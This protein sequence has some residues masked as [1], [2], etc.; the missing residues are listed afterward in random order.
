MVSPFLVLTTYFQ[1]KT[2]D[3]TLNDDEPLSITE[4][5]SMETESQKR[6]TPR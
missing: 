2:T 5:R 4:N 1:N 6:T 3:W